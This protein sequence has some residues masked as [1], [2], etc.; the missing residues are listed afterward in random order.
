VSQYPIRDGV[1]SPQVIRRVR[2]P[3][4]GSLRVEIQRSEKKS[5]DVRIR[6]YRCLE[7]VSLV[8]QAPTTFKVT[9]V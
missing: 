6:Y 1:S 7:C 4:C 9:V 5:D 2:C 3:I 8:S